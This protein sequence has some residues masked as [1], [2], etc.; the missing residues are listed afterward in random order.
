MH[1]VCCATYA[2]LRPGEPEGTPLGLKGELFRTL[3]FP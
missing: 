1:A 3:R 2:D